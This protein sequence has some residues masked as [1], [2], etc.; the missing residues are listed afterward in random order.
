MRLFKYPLFWTYLFIF[1]FILVWAWF[2]L[3]PAPLAVLIFIV[4]VWV[5]ALQARIRHDELVAEIRAR[6]PVARLVQNED[7]SFTRVKLR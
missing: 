1:L 7:G 4:P 6:G 5:M 3:H 2:A